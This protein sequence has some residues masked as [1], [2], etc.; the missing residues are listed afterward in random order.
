VLF[1]NIIIITLQHYH[2][3]YHYHYHNN[4][5][6]YSIVIK[7]NKSSCRFICITIQ[8]MI[9]KVIINLTNTNTNNSNNKD[10]NLNVPRLPKFNALINRPIYN[11]WKEN[12][13]NPFTFS[14]GKYNKLYHHHHHH[15][16][17]YY[18]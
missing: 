13:K 18:Y 9:R 4:N 10:I 6:P 11:N 7:E 12:A 15:H 5:N 17:Y 14:G 3:H 8:G 16:H 2:Y 1:N